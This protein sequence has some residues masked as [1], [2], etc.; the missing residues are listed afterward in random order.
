M[1]LKKTANPKVTPRVPDIA[2]RQF[3]TIDTI[4]RQC[5]QF[6]IVRVDGDLYFAARMVL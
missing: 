6:G 2:N 3:V 1:Y 5:S 4:E